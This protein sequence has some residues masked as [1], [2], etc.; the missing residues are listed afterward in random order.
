MAFEDRGDCGRPPQT[1]R[2]RW[3]QQNDETNRLR[4]CIEI[5]AQTLDRPVIEMDERRRSGR[6]PVCAELL[7]TEN[8]RRDDDDE[9]DDPRWFESHHGNHAAIIAAM[10]CGNSA[11]STT[12]VAE[13]PRI[14]SE[15]LLRVE[16]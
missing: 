8:G 7:L 16:H 11:T 2:S 3:R 15:P 1:R 4:C 14:A 13:I 6:C 9:N 10:T 12:I 5:G